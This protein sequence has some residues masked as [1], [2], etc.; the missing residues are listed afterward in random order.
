MGCSAISRGW[1]N[2]DGTAT[3]RPYEATNRD[4]MAA[5]LFRFAAMSRP[6]VNDYV[7]PPTSLFSDV[8]T[9]HVFYREISWMASTGISRGW[10]NGDGTW[11][12]EPY[13]P[14]LRDVMSV[15]L[16]RMAQYLGRTDALNY[17]AP[18]TSAFVDVPASHVFYREIS[19][20]FDTGIS[21][22]WID[23][24]TASY[25][26]YERTLRDVMAAFLHRLEHGGTRV[27]IPPCPEPTPDPE[28]AS[29]PSM[30]A[31]KNCSDFATW[32]EAQAFHDYYYQWYGDFAR[33]DGDNDG[34]ACEALK[35]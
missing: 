19:W 23:G 2:G 18:S 27:E 25:R 6:S 20:A 5:F 35:G 26:P 10:D 1:A 21:T 14:V 30:P 16:F 28:P 9:D 13:T 7:A 22:G 3:Y 31:D 17:V 33:L 4:V 34:V 8:A 12:Y 24:C 11:R 15:F 32:E 29:P